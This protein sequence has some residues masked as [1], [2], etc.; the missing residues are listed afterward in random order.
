M[1]RFVGLRPM[2]IPFAFIKGVLDSAVMFSGEHE[3]SEAVRTIELKYVAKIRR[4]LKAH[5]PLT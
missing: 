4:I 5:E 2:K 1:R 3:Q